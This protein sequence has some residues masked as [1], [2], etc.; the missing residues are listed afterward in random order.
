MCNKIILCPHKDCAGIHKT[1][2]KNYKKWLAKYTARRKKCK[3]ID[4]DCLRNANK[5][6]IKKQVLSS[7]AN[8]SIKDGA[9]LTIT[10]DSNQRSNEGT[11]KPWTPNSLILLLM[12]LCFLS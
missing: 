2:A 1:A 4:Y 7:M 6:K 12:C 9:T 3:G 11:P 5:E 8:S 10:D